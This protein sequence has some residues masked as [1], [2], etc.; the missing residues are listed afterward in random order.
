MCS[1][2]PEF[3]GLYRFETTDYILTMLTTVSQHNYFTLFHIHLVHEGRS[4][5]VVSAIWWESLLTM[6]QIHLQLRLSALGHWVTFA[7]L[8]PEST[9]PFQPCFVP[10]SS[11][12]LCNGPQTL[13]ILRKETRIRITIASVYYISR[14]IMMPW[15]FSEQCHMSCQ[16][17]PIWSPKAGNTSLP[18]LQ[19]SS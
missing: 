8:G 15:L 6:H 7:A 10:K 18:A 16:W 13:N 11:P 1:R 9:Q 19:M 3:Y 12:L 17:L 2:Y 5:L 14:W 4:H